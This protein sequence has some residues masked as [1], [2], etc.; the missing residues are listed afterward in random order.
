MADKLFGPV[1][2]ER[3]WRVGAGRPGPRHGRNHHGMTRTIIITSGK[4]G[5][6]KTNLAVNLAAA[7]ALAQQ[8]TCLFDVDLG[9]ANANLLLGLYPEKSLADVISGGCRL[10]E[11]MMHTA[12]FDIVP[13][14]SGV[15]ALAGLAPERRDGMIAALSDLRKYDFLLFD[16]SAGISADV[17]SFCLAAPEI[18][19]VIVPEVTSLTDAFALLKILV[20]NGF[21]AT[22]RVAVNRCRDQA[23]G[24]RVFNRF[25]QTVSQHL[26]LDLSLLSVIPDDGC[27]PESVAAQQPF[28]QRHPESPAALEVAAMARRLIEAP[29]ED[30]YPSGVQSF[31]RNWLR[32]HNG[33]LKMPVA[34]ETKKAVR[35]PADPPA[36]PPE[37]AGTG[38]TPHDPGRPQRTAETPPAVPH[39]PVLPAS[40]LA[41]LRACRSGE[42]PTAM[43]LR[44]AC[45]T[46]NLLA[47]AAA[48][49]RCCDPA[50]I[51][52]GIEAADPGL[53][54]G[55][56][57]SRVRLSCER[58]SGAD[59]LRFWRH[60]LRCALLARELARQTG[61]ADP[62]EAY[63][64]GLLHDIGKLTPAGKNGRIPNDDAEGGK[65]PAH[66]AAGARML[67]DWGFPPLLTDA[68]RYH[69]APAAE[70]RHAFALVKIVFV[71]N[72]LSC[73][74]E[75]NGRRAMRHAEQL[76]S[77]PPERLQ[78]MAVRADD[79]VREAAAGMGIDLPESTDPPPRDASRGQEGEA[80]LAAMLRDRALLGGWL[81]SLLESEGSAA[82]IER[83]CTVLRL[84]LD[85]PEPL[86]YV[87]D[88]RHGRLACRNAPYGAGLD[89]DTRA[90]RCLAVTCL[91]RNAPVTSAAQPGEIM[92]RQLARLLGREAIA[93]LPVA[94]PETFRGIVVMAVD[95]DALRRL[96]DRRRLLDLL[97]RQAG[98]AL[99]AHRR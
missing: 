61:A 53:I 35:L 64:A 68:V 36:A 28:V 88:A 58:I 18:I 80:E 50:D 9:L 42:G 38:E 22:V 52:R 5:V 92:D 34:Q 14:S 79:A 94:G 71:A 75:G 93:C 85:V 57:L 1:R 87:H 40:A 32:Y 24:R 23:A 54:E 8:A 77:V 89:I 73:R 13:G 12:G 43:V 69:H 30:L 45:L 83:V 49:G 7:L 47:L 59:L 66:A 20:Q 97:M 74:S 86:F 37:A 26:K 44:D 39:L 98:W 67:A 76:L 16:T 65:R 29:P 91:Q 95:D 11:I 60:S 99:E 19:L 63:L 25:R 81:Q 82:V 21:K 72:S 10:P 48:R 70:I 6:G 33:G 56:V 31:W 41:C 78:E 51:A 46:A 3:V 17:I 84:L 55:L 90:G 96:E 2:S 4:G 62:E 15:D 27:V